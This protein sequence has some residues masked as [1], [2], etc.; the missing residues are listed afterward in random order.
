MNMHWYSL[1]TSCTIKFSIPKLYENTPLH[2]FNDIHADTKNHQV[3]ITIMV[4][5]GN[6][7][8]NTE[9]MRVDEP[10]LMLTKNRLHH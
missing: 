8:I 6:T 2:S 5:Q 4:N 7:L 10:A 3:T 9:K 1:K